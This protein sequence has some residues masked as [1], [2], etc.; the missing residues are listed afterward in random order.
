MLISLLLRKYI[1]D[2][3]FFPWFRAQALFFWKDMLQEKVDRKLRFQISSCSCPL[4]GRS[5]YCRG[6][7]VAHGGLSG[8]LIYQQ[9]DICYFFGSKSNCWTHIMSNSIWI[10]ILSSSIFFSFLLAGVLL[11][12]GCRGMAVGAGNFKRHGEGKWECVCGARLR[13]ACLLA[14]H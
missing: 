6:A 7:R 10:L 4:A 13:L 2:N 14:A 5:D 1:Y 3:V 11:R 8:A 12:A 9:Y